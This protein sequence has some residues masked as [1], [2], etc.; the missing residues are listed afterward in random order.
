MIE[1]IGLRKHVVSAVAACLVSLA[2]CLTLTACAT[3]NSGGVTNEQDEHSAVEKATVTTRTVTFPA[4]YFSGKTAE[5]IQAALEEA[6]YSNITANE[7]GSYTVT[8]P[9]AK[10][11]ELV[12][13]MHE[14]VVEQ[15]NKMPNSE[16][17][18]SITAVDYDEQFSSVKIT[19][20]S[21]KLGLQES[22]APLTA[23]LIS[24]MYQQIAGQ[25]VNCVVTMVDKSGA[26]LS[27]ATYPDVLDQEQRASITAN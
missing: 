3:Q 24:C 22:F 12:D 20:S 15:L 17:W 9:I 16:D 7:S 11:N 21:S 26:E 18:P 6:G 4:A 14:A 1:V 27:S 19:S 10:Y 5:E 8:M 13:S 23:G 2:L 25:P